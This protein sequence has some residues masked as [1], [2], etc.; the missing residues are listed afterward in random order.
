M[1]NYGFLKLNDL[2]KPLYY[3]GSFEKLI[4]DYGFKKTYSK[5]GEFEYYENCLIKIKPDTRSF[6]IPLFLENQKGYLPLESA[7][8]MV[9]LAK[10]GLISSVLLD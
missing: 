10:N 3:T 1:K 8:M 7:M 5:Y 6:V 2:R 9:D 4:K